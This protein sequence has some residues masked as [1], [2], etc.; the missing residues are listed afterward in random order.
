MVLNLE[1][2]DLPDASVGVVIASHVLEHVDDRK[3][4]GEI[5]RIL[6]PGGRLVAMVPI[7]EGWDKT[8]ENPAI[9]TPSDRVAHF[10]QFDHVRFY[11][12]DFRDRV[13]EAGFALT[14][15]TAGGAE[16][17][18]YRVGRGSKVFLGIRA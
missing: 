9:T 11:G 13:T 10:G 4:L 6:V 2:I 15:R 7:I 8:Y 12:S 16:S 1:A 3:A 17:A 18:Q 14:E 5:H